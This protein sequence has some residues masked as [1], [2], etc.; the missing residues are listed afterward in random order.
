M[1]I[2]GFGLVELLRIDF[3]SLKKEMWHLL[4]IV[5]ATYPLSSVKLIPPVVSSIG[6][7]YFLFLSE[8]G[9]RGVVL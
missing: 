6:F 3:W 7:K 8:S 1:W 2:S 5:K 9:L 4:P